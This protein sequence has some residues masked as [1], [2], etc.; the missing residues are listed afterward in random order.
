MPS[1]TDGAPLNPAHSFR[2]GAQESKK[3]HFCEI[4]RGN[5]FHHPT[6]SLLMIPIHL[7]GKKLRLEAS[8][9]FDESAI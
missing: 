2:S 1:T 3:C 8:W 5:L 9:Q 4:L 7:L 6:I